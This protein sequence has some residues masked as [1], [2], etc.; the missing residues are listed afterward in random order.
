MELSDCYFLKHTGETLSLVLLSLGS[1]FELPLSPKLLFLI[2]FLKSPLFNFLVR[3]NTILAQKSSIMSDDEHSG[4]DHEGGDHNDVPQNTSDLIKQL[5]VDNLIDAIEE[6]VFGDFEH[7]ANIAKERELNLETFD[8]LISEAVKTRTGKAMLITTGLVVCIVLVLH[9]MAVVSP[10]LATL[11]FTEAGP[12]AG[13][14][15]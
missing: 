2:A 3:I 4:S 13:K 15:L 9:P 11:G 10:F 1:E 5:H 7:L 14:M 12:A 8:L 6:T